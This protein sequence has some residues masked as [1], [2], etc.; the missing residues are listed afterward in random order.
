MLFV[1]F[2]I[3]IISFSKNSNAS[4]VNGLAMEPVY[5][6][7]QI[8]KNGILNPLVR[9]GSKQELLF[10]LINLSNQ[11]ATISISPN[12]A[13]TSS[14]PSI[15]YSKTSYNYDNSLKNNFRSLFSKKKINLTLKPSKPTTIKFTANIPRDDFSGLLMGGFYIT[16]NQNSISN[17]SGTLINNKYSYVMPVIMRSNH[18]KVNPKLT[19]GSVNSSKDGNNPIVTSKIYNKQPAMIDQMQLDTKISDSNGNNIYHNKN[20]GNS[21]APNSNF[22]YISTFYDRDNLGPGTY[23]IKIVAKS[24]VG[25]WILQKDFTIGISQ[26]LG[27]ILHDNS[28]IWLIILLLILLLIFIIIYFIYKKNKSKDKKDDLSYMISRR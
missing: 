8:S 7:N 2:I 28:W 4:S 22:N 14:G 12:T 5:S 15:D 26:Y 6:K 20:S 19:L 11:D 1:T 24:P 23:R 9:P 10:N 16:S 27:V 21:V 18:V 17:N 25:S 3:C 13:V